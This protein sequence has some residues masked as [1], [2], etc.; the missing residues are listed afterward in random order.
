MGRRGMLV[1]GAVEALARLVGEEAEA[2]AATV[3]AWYSA[4]GEVA[5]AVT[6]HVGWEEP[7]TFAFTLG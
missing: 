6:Q 7:V 3:D 2:D 5:D 1:G 4:L